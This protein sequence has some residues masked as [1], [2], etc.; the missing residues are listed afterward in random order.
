MTW[1]VSN[2]TIHDTLRV[3]TLHSFLKDTAA[4]VF[5]VSE[6]SMWALIVEYAE[7]TDRLKQKIETNCNPGRR[8]SVDAGHDFDYLTDVLFVLSSVDRSCKTFVSG[9]P[10]DKPQSQPCLKLY[11]WGFQSLPGYAERLLLTT[12]GVNLVFTRSEALSPLSHITNGGTWLSSHTWC[13][14]PIYLI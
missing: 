6:E 11:V 13:M 9:A 5:Q 3:T 8:S 7:K 10:G 14:L 1:I 12:G 4:R 2:V